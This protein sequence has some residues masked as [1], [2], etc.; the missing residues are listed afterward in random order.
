[1]C[2]RRSAISAVPPFILGGQCRDFLPLERAR[3]TR[4]G[5]ERI[6][7]FGP[8]C[9]TFVDMIEPVYDERGTW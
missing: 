4:S 1:M 2:T 9:G 5:V 8:G 6:Q 7:T 3:A